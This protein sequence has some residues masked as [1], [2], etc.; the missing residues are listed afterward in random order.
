MRK[1]SQK[2]S[3]PPFLKAFRRSRQPLSGQLY[4]YATPCPGTVGGKVSLAEISAGQMSKRRIPTQSSFDFLALQQPANARSIA[5][6]LGKL[7][8]AVFT[9]EQLRRYRAPC[10]YALLRGDEVLYIGKGSSGVTRPLDAHHHRLAQKY[11]QR[12]TR[13]RSGNACPE[14]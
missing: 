8:T 9:F 13:S 10:V 12:G 3:I 6:I 14:P 5:E 4:R 2:V 11:L 1:G 7:S